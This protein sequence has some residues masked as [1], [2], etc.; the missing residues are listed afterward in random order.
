MELVFSP[1]WTPLE[2]VSLSTPS[3]KAFLEAK[4]FKAHQTDLNIQIW[5]SIFSRGF[6]EHV[7]D[8]IDEEMDRLSKCSLTTEGIRKVTALSTSRTLLDI[9]TPHL[10]EKARDTVKT[11]GKEISLID[12]SAA[13]AILN[14]AD[15]IIS[16][17]YYPAQIKPQ[18]YFTRYHHDHSLPHVI[19]AIETPKENLFVD[20]Y[21]YD[22][23]PEKTLKNADGVVG[24]SVG[25]FNQL[26]PSLTLA[27]LMK[28]IDPSVFIIFGGSSLPYMG[29]ALEGPE[30]FDIVDA[31]ILGE[32]ETPLYLLLNALE[33]DYSL[34]E[35]PNLIHKAPS[36][37][38]KKSLPHSIEDPNLLP[39]PSF[40]DLDLDSYFNTDRIL[41]LITS[42][43]CY[44][45]RCA[46]CSLCSTYGS[47]YRERD[48]NLVIED[49]KTLQDKH[50]VKFF[51][52]NDESISFHRMHKLC[53]AILEEG[54][55]IYWRAL[56]RP[57]KRF[58]KEVFEKAFKAG[59]RIVCM[60][61]ESGSQRVLTRMQKGIDVTSALRTIGYA[62]DA[63]VWTNVFT[64]FGF[65]GETAEDARITTDVI[66]NNQAIIDSSPI[67]FCRIEYGSELYSKREEFG[68]ILP[69]YDYELFFQLERDEYQVTG[70]MSTED[71][72]KAAAFHDQCTLK[73]PLH[74]NYYKGISLGD[75]LIWM[76]THTR[77][78]LKEAF[79]KIKMQEREKSEKSVQ[80]LEKKKENSV[81][82]LQPNVVY[83]QAAMSDH[84]R[85]EVTYC[86][87]Y[88]TSTHSFARIKGMFKDFLELCDGQRTLGAI[89]T[90]LGE[91]YDTSEDAIA[92][93]FFPVVAQLVKEGSFLTI[94]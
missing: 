93:M 16:S 88:N 19:E 45:N 42:R 63:G 64:I 81:I 39:P 52:F 54:L 74:M 22:D 26:L 67:S 59:C 66:V 41:P 73:Y 92:N 55:T 72:F 69:D 86:V 4:G 20:I 3:L 1:V 25:S 8:K 2:A 9:L 89:S 56:V 10:I 12:I 53:D 18:I 51:L 85:K 11:K 78:E 76:G 58:T 6:L 65:P 17:L 75:M 30:L 28:K 62:H 82:S 21:H 24:F 68:V 60:G 79:V 46:F 36:G 5:N 87:V 50:H 27:A 44:W 33:N 84:D 23:I 32:G 94:R 40:E 15:Y 91:K 71:V 70:G 47:K 7:S 83:S 49:I 80:K 31:F 48:M 14:H 37:A 77:D 29:K 13:G 43:G 38:I 61:L 90:Q 57:E 34:K 35:V